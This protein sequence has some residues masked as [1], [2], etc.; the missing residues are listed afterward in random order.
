MGA[1]AKGW[2]HAL[3]WTPPPLRNT[4]LT[5]AAT[6]GRPL[7]N[8]A[9]PSRSVPRCA[10]R[11]RLPLPLPP[12]THP[13]PAAPRLWRGAG[14]AAR[15]TGK[16][17]PAVSREQKQH[18]GTMGASTEAA[19]ARNTMAEGRSLIQLRLWMQHCSLQPLAQ[20]PDL[21]DVAP[22]QAQRAASR[23]PEPAALLPCRA[24]ALLRA[25]RLPAE[26]HPLPAGLAA[27]ASPLL[28]SHRCAPLAPRRRCRCRHHCRCCCPGHPPDQPVRLARAPT[29]AC[30]DG[31]KERR[32]PQWIAMHSGTHRLRCR[33]QHDCCGSSTS[34]RAGGPTAVLT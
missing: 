15:G 1:A 2:W 9:R 31:S 16:G 23:G 34:Q 14:P 5:V 24:P 13:P 11:R 30:T 4:C 27:P 20:R 22:F 6:E 18:P 8:S 26:R 7:P 21:E 12:R 10:T 33:H 3:C 32:E 29:G 25:L 17:T 28:S 19:C